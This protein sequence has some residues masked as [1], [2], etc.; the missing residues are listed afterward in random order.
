MIGC[1]WLRG[2]GGNKTPP[3]AARLCSY[4]ERS[5]ASDTESEKEREGAHLQAVCAW[6]STTNLFFF[7]KNNSSESLPWISSG[8]CASCWAPASHRPSVT[9][10]TGTAPTPSEY[11]RVSTC[12]QTH[13]IVGQKASVFCSALYSHTSMNVWCWDSSLCRYVLSCWVEYSYF[14][15]RQL[16]T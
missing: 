2:G 10:C 15:L 8:C 6:I 1:P 12:M 13:R 5:V 9:V 14:S 7:L 16:G 4:W 3:R 11:G